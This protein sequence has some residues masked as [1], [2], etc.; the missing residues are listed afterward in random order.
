MIEDILSK[1]VM[2]RIVVVLSILS[3]GFISSVL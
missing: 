1:Q 3:R 2:S